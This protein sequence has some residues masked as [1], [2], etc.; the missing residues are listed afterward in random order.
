MKKPHILIT[1]WLNIL[2]FCQ[3]LTRNESANIGTLMAV[4]YAVIIVVAI[5]VAFTL[6]GVIGA[7]IEN[8]ITIPAGSAWNA[9]EHP[10]IVTG[11]EIW[12][13]QGALLSAVVIIAVAAM[14]L[15]ALF[16]IFGG[17]VSGNGGNRKGG[18]GL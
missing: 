17:Q 15:M 6:A 16:A 10:D 18:G 13:T 4:F 11:G 9:T 14:A 2:Q 7:S 5:A 3:K 12:A 8:A 1:I